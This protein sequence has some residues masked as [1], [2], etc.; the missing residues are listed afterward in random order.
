L[1]SYGAIFR[2]SNW[3]QALSLSLS[4]AACH[5]PLATTKTNTNTIKK[6][7]TNNMSKNSAKHWSKLKRH[8]ETFGTDQTGGPQLILA[9][10][11]PLSF[12]L[13]P[14]LSRSPMLLVMPLYK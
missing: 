3:W 8:L 7:G 14:I 5:L 13:S 2:S 10:P 1:T 4:L 9:A 11:F 12:P 6:R